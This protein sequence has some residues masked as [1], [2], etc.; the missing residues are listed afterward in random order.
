MGSLKL[1]EKISEK[2]SDKEEIAAQ[3]I[4]KPELLSEIFAG[5]SADK[6]RIKYGCDK[7]LRI[8]SEK[9][10]ELLYPQMDFFVANL[11]SDNNFFK[12]GAIHVLANLA[13]VDSEN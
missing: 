4:N 9:K 8:I 6:A 1:H 10:P 3:V 7:V 11:D 13:S 5:L 2:D 12:W